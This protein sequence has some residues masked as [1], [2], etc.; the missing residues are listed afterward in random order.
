MVGEDIDEGVRSDL[1]ARLFGQGVTLQPMTVATRITPSGV[2][3]RHTFSGAEGALE[4][5]TVVL[6]FGGKANDGLFHDLDG[7]V[8]E[9]RVVGDA[10]APRR[11]HDAILEGTRAARAL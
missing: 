10:Y 3:T 2:A 6:A 5:D 7:R 9:L 8:A 11:I 4:A 1:Y